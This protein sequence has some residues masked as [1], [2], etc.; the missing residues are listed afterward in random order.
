MSVYHKHGCFDSVAD[1]IINLLPLIECSDELK[2]HLLQKAVVYWVFAY[3]DSVILPDSLSSFL[4]LKT[5]VS[6]NTGKLKHS[7]LDAIIQSLLEIG[8]K[9]IPDLVKQKFVELLCDCLAV[10][11]NHIIFDETVSSSIRKLKSK[12]ALGIC[13]S[14]S[15]YH[16]AFKLLEEAPN[17]KSAI[18]G[19]RVEIEHV[20]Y[21]QE[22]LDKDWYVETKTIASHLK[23]YRDI[24]SK[25]INRTNDRKKSLLEKS[26]KVISGKEL[27][28][29]E[30]RLLEVNYEY[31][32]NLVQA[33]Y[34]ILLFKS[35]DMHFLMEQ[36]YMVNYNL[37]N[38][39]VDNVEDK[40]EEVRAAIKRFENWKIMVRPMGGVGKEK[41]RKKWNLKW[42]RRAIEVKKAKRN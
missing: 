18:T 6:K 22:G 30:I 10:I 2:L 17:V 36:I 8:L 14:L 28:C 31:L 25:S 4:P 41:A 37:Q 19:T 42:R 23:A 33:L 24:R 13:K 21:N 5:T 29:G 34:R 1:T 12:Q 3:T 35:L 15:P 27:N 38:L 9:A 26:Y 32:E 11:L 7:V 20:E 39:G 16:V 40:I